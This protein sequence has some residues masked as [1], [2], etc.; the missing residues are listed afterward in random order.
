MADSLISKPYPPVGP[1]ASGL[2][3]VGDGYTLYW[4]TVGNPGGLPAVYLHGGPGGGIDPGVRRW[5]DPDVYRTV[6][7]DQRGCG[8]SRPLASDPDTDL[9]TNTTAHLVAD[10][11]RLRRHLDIDR[12]LVVGVSWGVTLALVYAQAHP[13]R[14][15]AMVLGAVTSGTRREID[16]I[17]R[18]IGRIFP[19]AWEAFVEHVPAPDR[20]AD[21]AAAY[22]RLL[23]NPDPDVRRAAA[24][25]WCAWE[26]THISLI[27]GWKPSD[28]AVADPAAELVFARLV[29]HYWSHQ[30]FL[31]DGHIA[32]GMGRLAGIPATLIH[33]RYDVSGPIETAWT[34]HRAWP[35]SRLI[36]VDDAGHGG[37]SFNSEVIAALNAF[38]TVG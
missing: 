17:T 15:R 26:D 8:N 2:L 31:T 27:P 3:D 19:R 22:A 13:D 24:Q 5:F 35:G 6:L 18:T 9:S 12:W 32:A 1:T 28:P 25:A 37:G 23:A 34:I 38:R 11:E 7:Y 36:V 29:T 16:W 4:E 14:V 10:L 20:H 33:G 30:C 21:L